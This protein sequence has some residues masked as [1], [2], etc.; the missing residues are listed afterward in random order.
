MPYITKHARE[1]YMERHSGV[2]DQHALNQL[3]GLFEVAEYNHTKT[4]GLKVYRV[5][6]INMV[7]CECNDSVITIY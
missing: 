5:M 2:S 7:Y 6:D 4:S 1:R 3:K